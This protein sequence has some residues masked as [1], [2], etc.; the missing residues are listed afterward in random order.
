MRTGRGRGGA[1]IGQ[2]H[3][4][5]STWSDSQAPAGTRCPRSHFS[6][7]QQGRFWPHWGGRRMGDPMLFRA[8]LSGA[9]ACNGHW[10]WVYCI[11]VWGVC[12]WDFA[13][14]PRGSERAFP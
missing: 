9:G 2:H 8:V 12:E 11:D 13:T 7:Y 14:A 6:R 1:T 5:P 4:G 10:G 3:G